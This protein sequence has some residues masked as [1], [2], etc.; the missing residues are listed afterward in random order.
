MKVTKTE[1]DAVLIIE[2]EV[3][4]DS[5]G[6]FYESY[7]KR[8]YQE[9][10]IAD[11]FVQDNHS[12][13]KKGALRGLHYQEEPGQ[14]KLV[15]VTHGEVFDVVVDVRKNS[16]SFG[17]WIGVCLSEGNRLQIYIPI[18]FAH[19]FCTLSDTAELLYKCSDYYNPAGERGIRWN[20]PDIGIEWPIQN[21]ILSEK[22][23]NLPLFRNI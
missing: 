2:P 10:G 19:G 15:R 11:D 8:K 20:D 18:G 4:R 1:L 5:R 9:R 12:L 21:P 22:D 3:H 6:F 13:S 23:K 16:P 17:K 7:V 14:A